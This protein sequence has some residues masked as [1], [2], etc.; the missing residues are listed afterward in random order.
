MRASSPISSS[1]C[2]QRCGQ[3]PFSAQRDQ[4]LLSPP[5][6]LS[7]LS[8]LPPPPAAARFSSLRTRCSCSSSSS[9]SSSS[10]APLLYL[11]RS[12]SGS[13]LNRRGN[14]ARSGAGRCA[15][16][17]ARTHPPRARTGRGKGG[18]RG[19]GRGRGRE[20]RDM[21]GESGWRLTTTRHSTPVLPMRLGR[22]CRRSPDSAASTRAKLIKHVTLTL[23]ADSAI[24]SASRVGPLPPLGSHPILALLGLPSLPHT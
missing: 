16:A 12:P 11:G 7:L 24:S 2:G 21:E 23:T 6:P 14:V 1:L 20:S 9:S 8:S 10:V 18:R 19:R 17:H 3:R 13:S 22:L 15:R 5:P 4:H